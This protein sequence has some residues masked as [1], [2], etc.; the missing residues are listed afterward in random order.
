VKRLGEGNVVA[1]ARAILRGL[2]KGEPGR[3]PRRTVVVGHRGAA[4]HEPE[5]TLSSFARALE[6]GAGGVEADICVTRDGRFVVWHDADPD[7]RVALAR[8]T[9]LESLGF[10]PEVPSLG[11]PLHRPVREL[12]LAEFLANYGYVKGDPDESRGRGRIPPI[13]LET[14]IAWALRQGALTDLF[15]DVKLDE[16]QT[17]EAAALV[18][19]VRERAGRSPLPEIHFLSPCEPVVR[20]MARRALGRTLRVSADFELPGADRLAPETGAPD[21]SMGCGERLWSGF[22]GDVGAC[23]RRRERGVFGRVVAWTIND[24]KQLRRLVRDGVDGILTDD[25]RLL[26]RIVE[27]ERGKDAAEARADSVPSQRAGGRVVRFE[28]NARSHRSETRSRRSP[29]A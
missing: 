26:R 18:D 20:E 13:T 1:R 8:Q 6:L 24:E 16:T 28:A 10:R 2:R 12:M 27:E 4:R 25:A 19:F 3:A 23:I 5:N 17:R 15:L 22:H 9:G 11:A 29:T 14:L 7:E 21:V